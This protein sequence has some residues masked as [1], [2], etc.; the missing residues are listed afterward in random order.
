MTVGIVAYSAPER[1][2][3][4]DVDGRADQYALAATAYHYSRILT[5]ASAPSDWLG[6]QILARYRRIGAYQ[7]A[8]LQVSPKTF[9]NFDIRRVEVAGLLTHAGC[10]DDHARHS[11]MRKSELQR[12][13]CDRDLVACA[14]L[15]DPGNTRHDFGICR[16]VVVVGTWDS[17]GRQ[18]ATV[19][20]AP[21]EQRDAFLDTQW[22]QVVE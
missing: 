17:T 22:H 10:A 16:Y 20:D 15:L 14:N 21:K 11:G 3:G 2:M 13:R 5:L 7:S 18:N 4:E 9:R 8:V 6:R 1:L 19:V 12:N